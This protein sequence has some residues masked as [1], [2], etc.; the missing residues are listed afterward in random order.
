MKV[1]DQMVLRKIAGENVLIPVGEMMSTFRGIM[2]LNGSG[3]L[4]WELLQ[5]E[6]TEAEL[7]AAVLDTYEVDEQTAAQ[8]VREFLAQL[9]QAKILIR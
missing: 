4:L 7:V 8:D 9:D 3:L 5:S 1:N 2:S 6:R